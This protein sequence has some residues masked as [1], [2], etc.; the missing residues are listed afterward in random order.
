MR[1]YFAI[2]FQNKLRWLQNMYKCAKQMEEKKNN[3][4]D[5]VPF[6]SQ[7]QENNEGNPLK[8]K[9]FLELANVIFRLCLSVHFSKGRI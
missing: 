3:E 4:E 2:F 8:D 7:Q 6:I 5:D 1:I 9:R